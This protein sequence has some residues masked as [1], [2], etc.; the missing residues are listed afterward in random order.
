MKVKIFRF[1][2]SKNLY[3]NNISNQKVNQEDLL[4]N[5]TKKT[6]RYLRVKKSKMQLK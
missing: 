2:E 4:I 1:I 3:E 5:T 6:I